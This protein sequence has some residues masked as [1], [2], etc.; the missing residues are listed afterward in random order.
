[1]K[2]ILLFSTV[3]LTAFTSCKSTDYK[4]NYINSSIVSCNLIKLCVDK[5]FETEPSINTKN[6]VLDLSSITTLNQKGVDSFLA[7]KNSILPTTHEDSVMTFENKDWSRFHV[8]KSMIVKIRTIDSLDDKRIKVNLS[9]IKSTDETI[10]AEIN[11]ER[12]LDTYKIINFK[13]TK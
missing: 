12:Y 2:F 7:L 11:F 6:Y 8:N 4:Q 13:R 1:M 9:K 10:E 3:L 5:A